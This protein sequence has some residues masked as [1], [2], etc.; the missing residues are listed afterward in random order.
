[1][2]KEAKRPSWQVTSEADLD[3]VVIEDR[4]SFYSVSSD[5]NCT[6]DEDSIPKST[7]IPA[8]FTDSESMIAKLK[9]EILH[10]EGWLASQK[11]G[12]RK[13]RLSL[14]NTIRSLIDT[15]KKLLQKLEYEKR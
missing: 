6:Q 15:R 9:R 7:L 1:M 8:S 13:S 3:R 12:R 5:V 14:S 11:Q 2:V 4:P 10:L